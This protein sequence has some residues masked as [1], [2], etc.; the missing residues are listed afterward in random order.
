MSQEKTVKKIKMR[1]CVSCRE[2]KR[3]EELLRVV[4]TS[5]E[6]F[7]LD[8]SGKAQGRGAYICKNPT[9]AATAKKRRQLDRS[10][11]KNVPAEIY[12]KII[13]AVENIGDE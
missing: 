4:K 13:S 8:F 1:R 11:K 10:F 5:D 3:K 7:F 6:K 2:I 9:C 12:D